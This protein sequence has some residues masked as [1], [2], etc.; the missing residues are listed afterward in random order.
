M[1]CKF[2]LLLFVLAGTLHSQVTYTS[3]H[4][5]SH[6]TIFSSKVELINR[7]I[8]FSPNS[9]SIATEVDNG[10]EIEVLM[11]REINNRNGSL[12]ISCLTKKNKPVTISLPDQE[13]VKFIDYFSFHPKTREEFQLRFYIQVIRKGSVG[14]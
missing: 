3:Y 1:K 13:P 5:E 6:P 14:F 10:K 7:S 8:T 9:I 2:F 12:I 4:T 11:I